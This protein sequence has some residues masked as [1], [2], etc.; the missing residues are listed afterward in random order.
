MRPQFTGFQADLHHFDFRS[1]DAENIYTEQEVLLETNTSLRQLG[2]T[3]HQSLTEFT[4]IPK[5]PL[6][7]I[8]PGD[9]FVSSEPQPFT[10]GGIPNHAFEIE[11][12]NLE[13]NGHQVVHGKK[14]RF[15][16]KLEKVF[17][18]GQT[19]I[20]GT[21]CQSPFVVRVVDQNGNP[22]ENVLCLLYTSPSPRD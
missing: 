22:R 5:L 19:S 13:T 18:D 6:D 20:Q 4:C 15:A 8:S 17:G 21:A 11:G 7:A 12:I 16:T 14:V 1:R 2:Q 3:A 10:G 9:Y